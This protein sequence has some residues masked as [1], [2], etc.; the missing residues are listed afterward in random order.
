M[1]QWREPLSYIHEHKQDS[2]AITEQDSVAVPA[3]AYTGAVSVMC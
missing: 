2:V 3:H 1:D